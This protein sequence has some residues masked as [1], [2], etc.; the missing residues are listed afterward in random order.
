[1]ADEEGGRMRGGE[2][3]F[4]MQ[5]GVAGLGGGR[6]RGGSGSFARCQE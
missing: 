4:G 3:A 2:S 5:G 1:M 6:G